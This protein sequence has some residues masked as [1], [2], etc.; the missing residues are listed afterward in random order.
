MGAMAEKIT[1]LVDGG[2]KYYGDKVLVS[3][4]SSMMGLSSAPMSTDRVKELEAVDGVSRVSAMVQLLLDDEIS[5]VSMGSPAMITGTD[6]RGLGYE[7]FE[8][9]FADGRD[10]RPADKGKVV[11]GA[12]LVDQLKAK[13][14]KTVMIRGKKF[15]VAGILNKTL[16]A[17]DSGV[18]MTLAD[19][20]AL[21]LK[22][23]PA[24]VQEKVEGDKLAT[25]MVVYIDEGVDPETV[26]TRIQDKYPATTATGPKAF[27]KQ[28][29][30]STSILTSIIFGIALISLLV[31]GL[32]VVNTMTMSVAERTR[33]IGIRKAIG[34]SNG[35][36]VRQFLAESG[37][38]S[39]TGGLVGLILGSLFVSAA[40]AGSTGT[41]LF[42]LTGRLVFGA[43]G[44]AFALGIL[45]GLYPSLHA[46]RM[47][48]VEALRYE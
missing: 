17:P 3:E 14:G 46:A 24:L 27:K 29:E 18:Q 43:L 5:A 23:L 45:S 35:R 22:T 1:I 32:S 28:V 6:G 36:I 10:I 40:N 8:V 42:L 16:T 13:V 37:V 44:F 47:N 4:G 41:P 30:D 38:I 25:G 11:V 20:Q 39:L 2:T 48:P 19:A 34:A 21:F 12:D 33:E 26:A 7:T 31:G 15:E 9:S